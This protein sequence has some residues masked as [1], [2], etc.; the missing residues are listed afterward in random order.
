MPT[1]RMPTITLET[2]IVLEDLCFA[3][4]MIM[5]ETDADNYRAYVIETY[6]VETNEDSPASQK[7]SELQ[8]RSTR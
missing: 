7:V 4:K 1:S 3:L 5:S 8:F 2:K 6:V